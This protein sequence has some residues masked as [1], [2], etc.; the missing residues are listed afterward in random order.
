MCIRDRND[1]PRSGRSSRSTEVITQCFSP[2]NLIPAARRAGSSGSG[3]SGLPVRVAQNLQALVQISPRIIKVAVQMCI[4]DRH[5]T[6]EAFEQVAAC[7]DRLI[8]VITLYRACR[9]GCKAVR[10][11]K[12]HCWPVV[13]LD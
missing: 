7:F 3:G 9:A 12:Y 6:A 10:F 13:D 4:R 1:E 2:N 5:M 11:G 8:K